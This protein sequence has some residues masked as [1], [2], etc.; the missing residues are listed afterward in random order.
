MNCTKQ[1]LGFLCF[2]AS[3][4]FWWPASY[5]PSPSLKYLAK[6]FLTF[7]CCFCI[8]LF[9]NTYR[10]IAIFHLTFDPRNLL[11]SLVNFKFTAFNLLK[12]CFNKSI[13]SASKSISIVLKSYFR[14]ISNVPEN[15]MSE[16]HHV[17]KRMFS[18]FAKNQQL[19]LMILFWIIKTAIKRKTIMNNEIFS[20]PHNSS[21]S[22]SKAVYNPFQYKK[23]EF[24]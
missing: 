9:Y 24:F 12:F 4:N 2:P 1:L 22:L 11:V 17:R 7:F 15:I 18:F 20:Q 14:R 6:T 10:K 3:K 13:I 5:S 8:I 23:H 16:K 21:F 19:V